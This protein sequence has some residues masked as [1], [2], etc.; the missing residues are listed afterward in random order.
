[1][2]AESQQYVKKTVV[3]SA[4]QTDREMTIETLEGNMRAEAGDYIIT[5]I[6]G[7]Q[8]PCKPDIFTKTYQSINS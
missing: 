4:Y 7:E 2:P 1:M 6:N 3:I 5:G 8:Y